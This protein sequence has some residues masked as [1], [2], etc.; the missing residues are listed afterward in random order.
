METARGK[1][2]IKA[3]KISWY[4]EHSTSVSELVK[5]YKLLENKIYGERKL[6]LKR[7]RFRGMLQAT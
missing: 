6:R 3:M 2:K 1:G 5:D 4:Y 7:I